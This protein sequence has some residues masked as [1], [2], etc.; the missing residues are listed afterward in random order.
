MTLTRRDLIRSGLIAGAAGLIVPPVLARGVLAATTDG[1]HNNRVLLVIQLGGGNDGL[2]TVV[3]LTDPAYAGLRPTLGIRPAGALALTGT[4]EFGLH[5]ALTRIQGL[6]T[7][8]KVAVVQ[9][10]GYPNPNY[11]HFESMY[12]WQHADP[13]GRAGDDGWLGAFLQGQIPTFR[14][15]L[16]TC[17]VGEGGT[18]L[19]LLAAA[20]P[21]VA[22]LP[23]DG[24]LR[25]WGG[26]GAEAEARA[27]YAATPG[28][29]GALLDG[30]VA[31]LNGAVDNLGAATYTPAVS[32]IAPGATAMTPFAQE[33]Q[34][35]ARLIATQA[36]VKI[37]HVSMG[38]FDTHQNQLVDQASLLTDLDVAVGAFM[39]DI[40]AHGLDQRVAVM[41]WSEFGR[42]AA[43]N[44]SSGTDHGSAG[45]QFV[46]G[47]PV[48]G[49]LHGQP[50]SLTVLDDGN[51]R[52][53][54]DLR[55]LYQEVI[56]AYLGGDAA[57]VLGGSFPALG[58][59]H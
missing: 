38:S 11:S 56:G 2:N 40:T 3:P 49:G 32:Y 42:R 16:T 59:F 17:A 44:G 52:F 12:V 34:T 48:A 21:P 45:P 53:T 20:R 24:A 58:L 23:S 7:S 41:T 4:T 6:Y 18:P 57:A 30:T 51:L 25:Y 50:C 1:I 31:T 29:W 36:G 43:E 14:T 35:A 5:P 10:V 37:I 39:Q 15:A 19:E 26:A 22:V 27:M 8:G 33:M 9:G 46:I 13:L 55:S 54:T 28:P 47:T